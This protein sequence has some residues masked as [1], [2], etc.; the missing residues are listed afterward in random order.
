MKDIS[1][2]FHPLSSDHRPDDSEKVTLAHYTRFHSEQ[3]G[4]PDLDGVQI[5]IIGVKEDRGHPENLGCAEGPDPIR[6]RFYPLRRGTMQPSIADLGNIQPGADRKDTYFALQ[7]VIHELLKKQILPVILG[8]SQDLSYA[9]YLAYANIEPTINVVAVDHRFDLGIADDKMHANT[10]LGKIILHQPNHL[11]NFSNV[12]YQ[13]YFIDESAADLMTKLYFDSHRLGQMQSSMEEV[14][15]IVRHADM[16]SFD[17]GAVRMSDAPGHAQPNPN[18]FYGEELC[19]IVRYAGMSDKLTSIGFYEYN[20][21]KDKRGQTAMLIGQALWYLL[22]GYYSR[23]KDYPFR[24]TADY[25]KYHVSVKGDNSEIIFYKSLRS[26]RWWMEVP[27]PPDKRLRVQRHCLVPC[28]YSDYQ[29]ALNEEVPD[30]WWQTF[31]KLG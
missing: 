2:Y 12:G 22:E 24:N 27:Y 16:L 23:K 14:E 10:W 20:P 25:Q 19:R 28:S 3:G 5:A 9:N 11:F 29:T 21:G 13:S 7:E 1:V 4:F 8:G 18:G 31:Q 26:D 30:R 17:I 15:P 6:E